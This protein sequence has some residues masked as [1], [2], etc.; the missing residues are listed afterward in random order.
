MTTPQHHYKGRF[1]NNTITRDPHTKLSNIIRWKLHAPKV[2]P[3]QLPIVSVDDIKN[4]GEGTTRIGH[5]TFWSVLMASIFWPTQYS[6]IAHPLPNSSVQNAR[7]HQH[8]L[9]KIYLQ[10]TKLFS[11]MIT[12]TILMK[13]QYLSSTNASNHSLSSRLNVGFGSTNA[14]STIGLN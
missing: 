11:R 2:I 14:A 3:K 4:R 10:S 5:A 13:T 6:L 1:R 12:T 7:H 9:L 8:V